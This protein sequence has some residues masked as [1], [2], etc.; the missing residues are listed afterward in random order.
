MTDLEHIKSAWRAARDHQRR[1]AWIARA[2]QRAWDQATI[3]ENETL[4]LMRSALA[5]AGE[6]L[7]EE[8]GE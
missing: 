5:E 8:D 2:A 7:P 1:A 4:R 6:P 3:V